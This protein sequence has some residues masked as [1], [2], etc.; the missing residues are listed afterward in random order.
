[1]AHILEDIRICV[2]IANPAS[3]A[4]IEA[5]LI[6]KKV[7]ENSTSLNELDIRKPR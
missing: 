4:S 5:L 2:T 6:Q 3:L 1:M 7:D